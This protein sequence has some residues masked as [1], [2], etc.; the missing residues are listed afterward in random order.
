MSI[1]VDPSI[2]LDIC[3]NISIG[4]GPSI[5]VGNLHQHLTRSILTAQVF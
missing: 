3:I 2:N 5:N 4:V 1:G